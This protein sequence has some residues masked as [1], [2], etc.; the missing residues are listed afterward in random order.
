MVKHVEFLNAKPPAQIIVNDIFVC[1]IV[2][3]AGEGA[4]QGGHDLQGENMTGDTATVVQ[5]H[6]I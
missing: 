4:R 5:L 1:V 2:L 6:T 3:R